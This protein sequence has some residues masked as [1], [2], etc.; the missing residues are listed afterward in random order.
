M[1]WADYGNGIYDAK[2]DDQDVQRVPRYGSEV[3]ATNWL[4]GL[5]GLA[6]LGLLAH[7]YLGG[8]R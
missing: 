3:Q 2:V 7:K 1:S 8:R 4:L 6:V 5:A